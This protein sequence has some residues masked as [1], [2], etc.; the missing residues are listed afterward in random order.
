MPTNGK[1]NRNAGHAWERENVDSFRTFFPDVAT[2]RSCNR[3]RDAQKVDLAYGDEHKLGRF[4]YNVQ[5]KNYTK[6]LLY[7]KLLSEMP[8]EDGIIN[9]VL[10]K[11]TAKSATGRFV[12][13][14]KYAIMNYDDF[15]KLVAFRKAFDLL[16]TVVDFVPDEER[17]ELERDL[18]K[19][20]L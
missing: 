9:V 12:V 20:G 8:Q 14:G 1:R 15:F 3:A 2:S 10:H 7:P 16:Q 17:K 4:P 18:E 11:Q 6:S 19:L 5:S 13:K